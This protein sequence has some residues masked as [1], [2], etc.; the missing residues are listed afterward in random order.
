L[1]LLIV[2]S[3]QAGILEDIERQ[4]M[5]RGAQVGDLHVADI[6][7]PRLD[8][9][10]VDLKRSIEDVLERA[11]QTIHTRLPAYEGDID[12]VVGI[13]HLQDLFKYAR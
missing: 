1:Q 13:L 9:V 11:A 7:I 4:V 6:M 12:H 10:A 2:Q 5:Q 8:I 3:H